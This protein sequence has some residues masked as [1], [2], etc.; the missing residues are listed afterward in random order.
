M[1]AVSISELERMC[2]VIRIAHIISTG[3]RQCRTIEEEP[4]AGQPSEASG[5]AMGRV[6]EGG[7]S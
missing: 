4:A 7:Q 3:L 6:S 2:G 5:Q 1:A